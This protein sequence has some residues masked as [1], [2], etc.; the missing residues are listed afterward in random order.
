MVGAERRAA[1]ELGEE[2]QSAMRTRRGLAI[3]LL[4][5]LAAV[6]VAGCETDD[7]GPVK[8]MQAM[9]ESHLAPY[10]GATLISQGNAPR[11][12]SLETG[13]YP[14]QLQR[15]FGTTATFNTVVTYYQSLLE[16]LGWSGCCAVWKKPGYKLSL[17]QETL[18]ADPSRFQG[19][20]LVYD[21]LLTE[22]L[23]ATPPPESAS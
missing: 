17:L 13:T 16:P 7:Y 9:P 5:L 1:G 11:R 23:D 6:S 19:Y 4:L 22:D 21:E 20:T 8:T 15:Q 14:A 2:E 18:R 10:P 3:C 12:S